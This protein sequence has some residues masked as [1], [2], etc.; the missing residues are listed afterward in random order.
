[1]NIPVKYRV[2]FGLVFLLTT[3][4]SLAGAAGLGPNERRAI[5]RGR[6]DVSSSL[7]IQSSILLN[8]REINAI[9]KTLEA[10]VKR[11]DDILSAALR[12]QKGR[13]EVATRDH[14][15][16]WANDKESQSVETHIEVPL[17]IGNHNWGRMEVLFKPIYADRPTAG[18]IS[19]NFLHLSLVSILCLAAFAWYLGKVLKQLDPSR[20]VPRHVED[21]L[22]TL[23][24]GLI[25]TDHK[26]TIRLANEAFANW[27]GRDAPKLIGSSPA[28]LS[29]SWGPHD[30]EKSPGSRM[31]WQEAIESE[32]P[33]AGTLLQLPNQFGKQMTLVANSSPIIGAKGD[34][35]GVLTSFEDVTDLENHKIQLSKAKETADNANRAKSEFLARMSHEIRTPMNA[36]LGYAEVLRENPEEDPMVRQKHLTTIHSSGE[37]LLSL[38][39]DILDL[40]KIESGQM[41]LERS[42]VSIHKLIDEVV[43]TLAMKA[44]E[45]G[46]WLK[47]EF[48]S[49]MPVQI[50]SDSVRLRQTIINLIGNAIKFTEEGGVTVYTELIPDAHST[51]LSIQVRDTGIGMTPEAAAKIFQPFSQADTSITRRF[52]GTGLGLSICKELAEKMGGGIVVESTPGVGSTFNLTIDIG[53]ISGVELVDQKKAQLRAKEESTVGQI[54]DLPPM[55][56]LIVDDGETNRQ[57]VSV[58]LKKANVT[59]EQAENGRIAVEKVNS[60]QFDVV[61][62]DMHMPEMDGFEAT[63]TLRQQGHQLPIIALTANAMVQDKKDCLKAGCSGFLSKPINR[64]RLFAEL[65]T[66]VA[67]EVVWREKQ[68]TAQ[69][70][71]GSMVP[72]TPSSAEIPQTEFV[73][74]LAAETVSC[75]DVE[76]AE[77]EYFYSSLPMDDEDFLYVAELFKSSMR[78]KAELMVNALTPIDYEQLFRLGHWLKGSSGTA[79]YDALSEPGRQLEEAA[80]RED[81]RACFDLVREICLLASRVRVRSELPTTT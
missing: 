61:L 9:E 23:T 37:H 67:G 47:A 53:D 17:N 33:V 39:N 31:P 48:A 18:L 1:M 63:R 7:A 74:R 76:A 69:A 42:P 41:E 46:I 28:E 51:K 14:E 38:I 19:P 12:S 22:N 66:A 80:K 34:Y 35:V 29:W 65:S 16:L 70:N 11:N 25:L 77:I 64:E 60:G 32:R 30:A 49:A 4:M 56:V 81:A 78:E 57:L 44:N 40:S 10:V 62:M 79:G 27:I 20:A 24:E 2:T 6:G 55:H 8:R 59:F 75:D 73:P 13:V 71:T 45:K 3:I 50:Q 5:M 21:A 54:I 68:E 15:T 52:G 26:G 58:Y 43:S 72:P 36:I